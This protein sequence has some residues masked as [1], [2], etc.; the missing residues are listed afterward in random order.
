VK[1]GT[2]VRHWDGA[3]PDGTARQRAGELMRTERARSPA[4]PPAPVCIGCTLSTTPSSGAQ[5]SSR[6]SA[7]SLFA[8]S[9]AATLYPSASVG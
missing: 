4:G 5:P 1:N 2:I 3:R 6:A 7:P 8:A 9:R